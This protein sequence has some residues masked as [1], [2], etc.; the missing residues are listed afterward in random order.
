MATD[1]PE[2]AGREG[3]AL[4]PSVVFPAPC[5]PEC[6]EGPSSLSVRSIIPIFFFF[7][8]KV[9]PL[10]SILALARHR[11]PPAARAAAVPSFRASTLGTGPSPPSAKITY[12]EA[13][14]PRCPDECPD[15]FQVES[16]RSGRTR[17]DALP[18]RDV[19]IPTFLARDTR[20]QMDAG[21]PGP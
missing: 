10:N 3:G 9:K 7:V 12:V 1:G 13:Y 16:L 15:I 19:D 6:G 4:V 17:P 5:S 11:L 2:E 8:N 20:R 18:P 14:M 21:T